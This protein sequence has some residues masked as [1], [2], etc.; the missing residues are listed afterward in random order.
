VDQDNVV[1]SVVKQAED[2]DGWIVRGYETERRATQATIRLPHQQRVIET[3]FGP[4]EIKTFRVP[5]DGTRPVVETDLL[6]QI[7]PIADSL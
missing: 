6:E 3:H 5:Q 1:V 2:G 7:C 4:C